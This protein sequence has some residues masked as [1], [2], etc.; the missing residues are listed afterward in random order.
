MVEVEKTV[1]SGRDNIVREI[2]ELAPPILLELG[3]DTTE[4]NRFNARNQTHDYSAPR[5]MVLLNRERLT[6]AFLGNEVRKI[7]IDESIEGINACMIEITNTDLAHTDE[8]QLAQYNELQIFT[9]YANGPMIRRG[10]RFII[11]KVEF[12]FDRKAG[13]PIRLIGIGEE[14]PLART[15]RRRAFLNKA[16]WQIARQIATEMGLN[17]DIEKTEPAH[18]QVVQ[19]GE[20]DYRFLQ[21]RAQLYGFEFYVQD[22]VLHFHPPRFVSTGFQW[23]YGTGPQAR[24]RKFHVSVDGWFGGAQWQATQIDP[25][26]KSF[27]D[28]V[29]DDADVDALTKTLLARSRDALPAEEI[30]RFRDFLDGPT[31]ATRFVTNQG[32]KQ[33]EN[34]LQRIATSHGRSSRWMIRGQFPTVAAP[35]IKPRMVIEISGV[36]RFAGEYYVTRVLHKFHNGYTQFIE[37]AQMSHLPFQD[38]RPT[39]IVGSGTLGSPVDITSRSPIVGTVSLP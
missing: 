5:R 23:R 22:D 36:G 24:M 35:S 7:V 19:A 31:R 12:G 14:W 38:R 8:R 27:I 21:T 2:G 1:D 9:G 28:V 29:S 10:S 39:G 26:R 3:G 30:G 37:V 18:E 4:T 32:H 11:D 33:T 17:F 25:L 34:S 20:T 6:P 13:L 16:D 15:E